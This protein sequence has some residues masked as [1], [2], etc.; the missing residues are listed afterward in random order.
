MKKINYY[1]YYYSVPVRQEDHEEKNHQD[2]SEDT[3][4]QI[5]SRTQV[6]KK[7]KVNPLHI[8]ATYIQSI[9]MFQDQGGKNT[10]TVTLQI[11]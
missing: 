3:G 5:A 4:K 8:I 7:W 11:K 10:G 9:W 2:A 6:K 1:Y